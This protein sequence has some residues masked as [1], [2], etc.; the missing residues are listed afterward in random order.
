[1]ANVG[2]A[3]RGTI[4]LRLPTVHCQ[5]LTDNC[6]L[7]FCP[8]P[9]GM[10]GS[11]QVF[12]LVSVG[13]PSRLPS[14]VWLRLFDCGEGEGVSVKSP[15][16]PILHHTVQKLTAAGTAPDLH[17]V[18]VSSSR[19]IGRNQKPG[20]RSHIPQHKRPDGIIRRA[21]LI[22]STFP[23]FCDDTLHDE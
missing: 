12:W 20:R 13:A 5:L 15:H 21:A 4:P 2:A 11:W 10:H 18:P 19:M 3:R 22:V 8:K 6:Q 23:P 1:M 17:R 16:H 7:A 9:G 14:G